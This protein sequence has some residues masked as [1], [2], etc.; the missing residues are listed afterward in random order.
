MQSTQDTHD[1][2]GLLTTADVAAELGVSH[3]TVTRWCTRGLPWRGRL[4]RL[5]G[6][7][8]GRQWRFS[9]QAVDAFLAEMNGPRVPT[10]APGAARAS[11]AADERARRR[12][13]AWVGL[14]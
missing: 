10:A 11:A 2:P 6:L 7:R 3:D 4:L 8:V 1:T 13:R 5:D 9:R 14:D 12:F